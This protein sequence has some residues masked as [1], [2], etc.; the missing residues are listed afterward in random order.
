MPAFVRWLSRL[1]KLILKPLKEGASSAIFHK[2]LHWEFIRNHPLRSHA[3]RA[4]EEQA[5]AEPPSSSATPSKA[6][7]PSRQTALFPPQAII[8]LKGYDYAAEGAY[9]VT[10]CIQ[11][12]EC[13]LGRGD[14][15]EPS[16][17]DGQ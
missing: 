14:D 8:R 9:F 15:F 11:K 13:L 5:V 4:A 2:E 10:M 1:G 7:L 17:A 6:S 16:G 12:R 3:S